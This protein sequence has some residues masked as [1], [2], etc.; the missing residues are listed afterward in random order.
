MQSSV[1]YAR[2]MTLVAELDT[3]AMLE[4]VIQ[5]GT[6]CPYSQAIEIIFE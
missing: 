5:W 1:I 3:L 4:I 6:E 2:E